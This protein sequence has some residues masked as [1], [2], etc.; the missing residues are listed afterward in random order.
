MAGPRVGGNAQGGPAG[1]GGIE[2]G[3][4]FLN[5]LGLLF[6]GQGS[7]DR[8][9]DPIKILRELR[10]FF[11]SDVEPSRRQAAQDALGAGSR[12]GQDLAA[13]FN[14]GGGGGT[15]GAAAARSAGEATGVSAALRSEAHFK[16]MIAQL[17]SQAFSGMPASRFQQPAGGLE[18][19]RSNAAQFLQGPFAGRLVRQIPGFEKEVPGL[20]G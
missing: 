19:F 10:D 9:E 1:G 7:S 15:A 13:K 20:R 2:F 16:Q 6:A 5:A 4:L 17:T 18:N 8:R 12:V 11:A 3:E 14:R